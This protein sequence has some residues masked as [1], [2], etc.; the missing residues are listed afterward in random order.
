MEAASGFSRDN[1][2]L[3]RKQVTCESTAVWALKIWE[4]LAVII[5]PQGHHLLAQCAETFRATV[6]REE[7]TMRRGRTSSPFGLIVENNFC[8][9]SFFYREPDAL[10]Q[11]FLEVRW[12]PHANTP[13]RAK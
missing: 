7:R 1:A 5:E 11:A 2:L 13:S 9:L 10:I 4:G 8:P 12:S 3:A 6:L